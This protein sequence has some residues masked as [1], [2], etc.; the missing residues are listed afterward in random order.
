MANFSVSSHKTG[1]PNSHMPVVAA[2]FLVHHE[3]V[4]FFSLKCLNLKSKLENSCTL[5]HFW[6]IHSFLIISKT[7]I[8]RRYWIL[9]E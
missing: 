2:I 8:Y 4:P 6:C 5:L 1:N 9:N 3:P 7:E